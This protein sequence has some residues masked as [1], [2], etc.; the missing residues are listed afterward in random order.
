MLSR[1]NV[2]PK[3]SDKV[4]EI[5]NEIASLK[6]SIAFSKE[7]KNKEEGELNASLRRLKEEHNLS[8]EEDAI[9]NLEKLTQ[10]LASNNTEILS[11]YEDLKKEFTW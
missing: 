11:L 2:N 5:F 4:G 10:D 1:N 9:K 6:D 7:A 3:S 8:S